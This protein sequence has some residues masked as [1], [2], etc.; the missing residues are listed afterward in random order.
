MKEPENDNTHRWLDRLRIFLLVLTGLVGLLWIS[1]YFV[2]MQRYRSDWSSNS[3]ATSERATW[4]VSNYGSFGVAWRSQDGE[5]GSS[6]PADEYEFTTFNSSRSALKNVHPEG[7]FSWHWIHYKPTKSQMMGSMR[8]GYGHLYVPYWVPFLA[9]GVWA[10]SV[11]VY[12]NRKRGL[13]R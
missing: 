13:R 10:F 4:L 5:L 7:F 1:S 11:S 8:S 12:L 3:A 9:S 2:G 6:A